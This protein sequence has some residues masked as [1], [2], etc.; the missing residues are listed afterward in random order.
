MTDAITLYDTAINTSDA[1]AVPDWS[2]SIEPEFRDPDIKKL[3]MVNGS[4]PSTDNPVSNNCKLFDCCC[5][6][7]FLKVLFSLIS[8]SPFFFSFQ[9]GAEDGKDPFNKQNGPV[10]KKEKKSLFD[11]GEDP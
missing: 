9:E 10:E 1:S 11:D 4:S 5:V 7:V 3:I 8:I 2:L 6:F